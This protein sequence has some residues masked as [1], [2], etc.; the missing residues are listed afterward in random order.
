MLARIDALDAD[1]AEVDG[2]IE[3]MTARFVFAVERLNEIPA[4]APSLPRSSS[5][6]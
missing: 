3:A 6:K 1:I 2:R 5:P 4:S